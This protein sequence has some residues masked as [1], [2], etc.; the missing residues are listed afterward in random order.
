MDSREQGAQFLT[1]SGGA[2]GGGRIAL[3]SDGDIVQGTVLVDGGLA[4]G[5]GSAGQPG[6]LVIGLKLLLYPQISQ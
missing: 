6:S 1:N 5:D 2:G 3:I 4:N